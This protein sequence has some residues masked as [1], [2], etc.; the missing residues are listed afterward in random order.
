MSSMGK[1]IAGNASLLATTEAF[2]RTM[3]ILLMIAVARVLGPEQM[4]VYAFGM[5]VNRIFRMTLDFGGSRFIQ[6]EIGKKPELSGSLMAQLLYLKILIFGFVIMAA[7]IMTSFM[8]ES[9]QKRTVIWLL[10]LAAF[11]QANAGSAYGFFRAHL[12][13]KFEALSRGL[14]RL[15]YLFGGLAVVGAG[16]NVAVLV[17]VGLV[18]QVLGCLMAWYW[19]IRRYANPFR[20]VALADLVFLVRK[21]WPFVLTQWLVEFSRSVD[22][23]ILSMLAT[24]SV[25]GYYGVAKRLPAAFSF[26][27]NA[28]S[29]AML[30]TLSRLWNKDKKAF[31]EVFSQYVKYHAVLGTVFAAGLGAFAEDIIRLLF[32]N[33]FLQA[34][35]ALRILGFVSFVRF[36]NIPCGMSLLSRDREKWNLWVQAIVVAAIA[37]LNLALIPFYQENGSAM[38]LL[39]AEPLRLGLFLVAMGHEG[40]GFARLER[41]AVYPALV[42]LFTVGIGLI[43]IWANW[44]LPLRLAAATGVFAASIVVTGAMNPSDWQMLQ[45]LVLPRR[46]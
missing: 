17:F 24:D 2:S 20:R 18:A 19:F 28:I 34:A 35:V 26:I 23:L 41:T 12:E 43:G 3:P 21:A 22:M 10:T 36:V 5:A 8:S 25:V 30:P 33:E 31:G 40:R 7:W 37:L 46:S 11:F 45:R 38:A 44:S 13:A 39:I 32:G 15:L 42:I 29:S 27:P 6:R 9:P 14:Y 1:R 16:Y 4:G